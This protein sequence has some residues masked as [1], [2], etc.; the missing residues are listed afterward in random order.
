MSLQTPKRL[1]TLQRK[2]YT[3]AN[4][5]PDFRFYSLIDK[6]CRKET[7]RHAWLLVRE[8]A[9]SSGVDGVTIEQIE[10]RGEKEWLEEIEQELGEQ[11]YTAKPVLRVTIP[12]PAGG[13]RKLGIPTVK[14]R[15]VQTAVKLVIEPIFEADL[16]D[17]AYGYRPKRS[18]KDAIREVHQELMEGRTD[19]V[20]A[21]LS[22]YFD[23]I[24]HD[25]LMQSVRR[26]ISDGRILELINMWLKAP[27]VEEDDDGTRRGRSNP[28]QGTPQ[29]GVI[30]PLLANIYINR[31]LKFWTQQELDQ[32]LDSRIVNYADDFVI[33]TRG[34]AEEALKVTRR[35]MKAMGLKLNEQ[36]TRLTDVNQEALEFLGYAFGWDYYKPNGR[37]YLSARPAKSRVARMK[38]KVKTWFGRNIHRRWEFVTYKLNQML[39]GWANYFSYGSVTKTWR[40]MDRYVYERAVATLVRKHGREGRGKGQ[41]SGGV[42]YSQGGLRRLKDLKPGPRC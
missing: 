23:T 10:A 22:S 40:T 14:D 12:K 32:K 39:R 16:A 35:V 5:E 29:G 30:S 36:K 24:P 18:A 9:G 25:Q 37:R 38:R 34:H 28:G 2:L 4:Q 26:R 1:R 21:D 7:L 11:T 41:W 8:N 17:E 6:V 3:K 42:M 13:Q 15:V 19:V 20:D 27:V 33:L 31:F